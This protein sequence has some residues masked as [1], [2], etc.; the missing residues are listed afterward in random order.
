MIAAHAGRRAP[1]FFTPHAGMPVAPTKENVDSAA[2]GNLSIDLPWLAGVR[3]DD[4]GGHP[5]TGSAMRLL[6]FDRFHQNNCADPTQRL[7]R[8]DNIIQLRGRINTEVC[9]QLHKE[10]NQDAHFLN[11][12]AAEKHLFLTRCLIDMRN[13]KKNNHM[14][15]RAT[16]MGVIM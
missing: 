4:D 13:R 6:L 15:K 3:A 2:Q 11:R 9:E 7:R 5:D 14:R 10:F 16:D 12:A 8:V 1:G